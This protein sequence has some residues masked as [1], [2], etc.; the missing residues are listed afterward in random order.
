MA[1]IAVVDPLAVI[2]LLF[3]YSISQ[4]IFST[5]SYIGRLKFHLIRTL[6]SEPIMLNDFIFHSH[7]LII[8]IIDNCIFSHSIRVYS[9]CSSWFVCWNA[10]CD[11]FVSNYKWKQNTNNYLV[12]RIFALSNFECNN[13]ITTNT[14]IFKV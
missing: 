6:D 8:M 2:L 14:T 12:F 5:H 1:W 4:F 3:I 10:Y 7:V 11:I 13:S 9:S